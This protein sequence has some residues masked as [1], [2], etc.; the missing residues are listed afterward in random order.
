MISVTYLPS[1]TYSF[2]FFGISDSPAGEEELH[3]FNFLGDMSQIENSD[4]SVRQSLLK[5][6]DANDPIEKFEGEGE[7]WKGLDGI[8]KL[9]EEARSL[10]CQLKPK[11]KQRNWQRSK[12]HKVFQNRVQVETVSGPESNAHSVS[13]KTKLHST[14]AF[15]LQYR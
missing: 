8:G 7:K 4:G 12:T 1:A 6:E 9:V 11:S 13:D 2:S 10:G 14:R 15:A 5:T 3:F